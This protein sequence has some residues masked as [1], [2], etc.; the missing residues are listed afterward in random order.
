MIWAEKQGIALIQIQ[1]GKPQQ[2]AQVE[3]Y[4]RTARHEW[5][6]LYIFETIED[7]E[8]I[9]TDWVW[10]YNNERP[11]AN[12]VGIGPR[13]MSAGIGRHHTRSE[14]EDGCLKSTSTPR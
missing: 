6:D 10:A 2:N 5:L 12:C 14:T 1:P 11:S 3:R 8:E 7:A 13:P 4:N 9:A